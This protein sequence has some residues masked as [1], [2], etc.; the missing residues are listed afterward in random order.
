M[1]P[2]WNAKNKGKDAREFEFLVFP[3]ERRKR[4]VVDLGWLAEGLLTGFKGIGMSMSNR[5]VRMIRQNKVKS[6][7][8]DNNCYR[9]YL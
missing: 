3:Q 7:I 5:L 2:K 8:R 4:V 9:N 6:N 1:S